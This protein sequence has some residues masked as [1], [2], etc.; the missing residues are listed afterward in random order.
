M[1]A[2]HVQ[3]A[4]LRGGDSSD[5]QAETGSALQLVP[6]PSEPQGHW[7][8]LIRLTR[9]LGVALSILYF[10][11]GGCLLS[12]FVVPYLSPVERDSLARRRRL[13]TLV[14]RIWRAF[15]AWL[16]WSTL[17]RVRYE[18]EQPPAGP[19][20]FVANHPSL[21]DVTA[22]I[23]RIP[24]ACCVVKEGL[25][26]NPLVGPLIR[27]LGHVGAGD[28]GF[29]AGY[30][31]VSALEARLAEGFPVLIFPEGTRSPYS[32]M[33]RFR[34]GAFEVARIRSV[35]LV[36]LFLR[37]VPPALGKGVPVWKHPRECPTLTV[38]VD[39]PQWL[40]EDSPDAACKR[41]QTDFRARLGLAVPPQTAA[42]SEE[43]MHE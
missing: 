26:R 10:W 1:V 8:A 2:E 39:S 30:S 40:G 42:R 3:H 23:C 24:H 21:L 20:V 9:G 37:C 15:H 31:V 17:Y 33:R 5:E 4:A 32:G 36:P 14:A 34:R 18:G 25:V 41:V 38:H 29:G 12:V 7:A 22:V 13:Q 27:G 6:P 35:P 28:G 11:T 16:D 19:A 43:V